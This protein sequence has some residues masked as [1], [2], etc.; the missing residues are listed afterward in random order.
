MKK[1]FVSAGLVAIGAVGLHADEYAPDFTAMDATKPWSVSGTFRGFYDDNFTTTPNGHKQGSA[2]FEVSPQLSLIVP[3]QQTELGLRYTYGLYYY[4][5][6]ENQGS[7]P[8]DQTHQVDLW[9]DHAF[10]QRLEGKVE[11]TFVS[12]QDPQ[13][14]SSGT[15]L[16]YRAEGN[17]IQ[18]VGTVSGHYEL[19]ALF[20]SDLSYQNTWID[21]VNNIGIPGS[22]S[23]AALLN[24]DEHAIGLTLNY[25]YLPDLAFMVGYTFQWTDYTGDAP[26]GLGLTPGEVYYSNSRN[27]LSHTF[28]VG[29]QYAATENLSILAWAGFTYNDNYNQPSFDTQSSTSLQPYANIAV[30]Y[31]YLPGDYVQVGFSES[32]ASVATADISSKTGALTQYQ[33]VS[34][35]YAT[36]NHQI[37]PK[38][39]GSLT[40]HY[41]YSTYVGGGND[42]APQDWYSF[43]LDLAYAFTPWVSADAGYN[44]YYL[45]SAPGLQGY[46]RNI[47]YASVTASF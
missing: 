31:T 38:L 11:D 13:L 28:K 33:Q 46:S 37:T 3:L 27:Q 16:P 34:V 45:T 43:G 41:Q 10:T 25:Q 23:Y 40:G 18:N 24:Q 19:S 29:A 22:P 47:G 9:V 32:G 12:Q 20:S 8:I 44:F 17:N 1:L 30:T 5:Q 39:T 4:Q 36:I 26:I 6:R 2:G 35:L 42:G 14:T 21:Y 7:N 15:I